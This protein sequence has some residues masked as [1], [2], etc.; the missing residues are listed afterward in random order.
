M[1]YFYNESELVWKKNVINNEHVH[2]W[3]E[4]SVVAIRI[5]KLSRQYSALKA[6]QKRNFPSPFQLRRKSYNFGLK[7]W[8]YRSLNSQR[9]MTDSIVCFLIFHIDAMT[10][11]FSDTNFKAMDIAYRDMIYLWFL[12]ENE[13]QWT[14]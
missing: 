13:V 5:I 2:P 1:C 11:I 12:C 9:V 7:P 3:P 6:Q 4:L 8:N 14:K 10:T